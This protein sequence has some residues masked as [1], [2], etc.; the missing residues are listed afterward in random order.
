MTIR[1]GVEREIRRKEVSM[2]K[3]LNLDYILT[4]GKRLVGLR[5]NKD[6]RNN[7]LLRSRIMKV[8]P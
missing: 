6:L 2:E 7:T 3:G 5:E 4:A 8:L 1:I